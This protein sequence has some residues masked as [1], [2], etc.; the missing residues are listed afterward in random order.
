M[1]KT[2]RSRE[3]FRAEQFDGSHEQANKYG[4]QLNQPYATIY[5]LPSFSGYGRRRP[6]AVGD[7]LVA[8]ENGQYDTIKDEVFKELYEEVIENG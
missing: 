4:A 7:W 1:I 8:D 6:L 2:F 3:T 5:T